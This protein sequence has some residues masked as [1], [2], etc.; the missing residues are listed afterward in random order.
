MISAG[1][2]THYANSG[3]AALGKEEQDLMLGLL[4]ILCEG[5]PE[6]AKYD[7]ESLRLALEAL[8]LFPDIAIQE[9]SSGLTWR[10]DLQPAE[11]DLT[12]QFFKQCPYLDLYVKVS[13]FDSDGYEV[14][15]GGVLVSDELLSRTSVLKGT[16]TKNSSGTTSPSIHSAQARVEVSYGETK[17][18]RWLRK[19][20]Q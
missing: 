2:T 11:A 19:D 18:G 12:R 20:Y 4:G 3:Y 10:I 13:L 8:A 1:T 16:V 5:D 7:F 17:L 15:E 14:L 6:P 9:S